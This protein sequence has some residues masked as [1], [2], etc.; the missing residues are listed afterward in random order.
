MFVLIQTT[1]DVLN[2]TPE[3]AQAIAHLLKAKVEHHGHELPAD[4][5]NGLVSLYDGE[6]AELGAVCYALGYSVRAIF[7]NGI[8]SKTEL[9]HLPGGVAELLELSG[10][11]PHAVNTVKQTLTSAPDDE[12]DTL[13]R[14]AFMAALVLESLRRQG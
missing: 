10:V 3:Q 1:D 14:A 4:L 12:R 6:P 2:L 13:G 5:L 7:D 8:K 9:H 11:D